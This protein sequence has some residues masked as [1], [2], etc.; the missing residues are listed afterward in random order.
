MRHPCVLVENV[1]GSGDDDKAY[2]DRLGGNNLRKR[3][4]AYPNDLRQR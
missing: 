4:T 2:D 3:I 1:R